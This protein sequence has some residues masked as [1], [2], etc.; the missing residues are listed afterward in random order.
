[1]FYTKPR[2]ITLGNTIQEIRGQ[3]KLCTSPDNIPPTQ[4]ATSTAYEADE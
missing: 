4:N 2:I 1:M 3:N